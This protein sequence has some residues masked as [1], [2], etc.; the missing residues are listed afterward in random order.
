MQVIDL[1]HRYKPLPNPETL[2]AGSSSRGGAGNSHSYSMQRKINK[3]SG[4][5]H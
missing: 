1:C 4:Y 3:K 2:A 5:I